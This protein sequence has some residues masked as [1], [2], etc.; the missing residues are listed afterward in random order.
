M[1]GVQTCALPI[2]N[3]RPE[4]AH[5]VSGGAVLTPTFIPGLSLSADWYAI[6]LTGVIT[7]INATTIVNQ[8][9]ATL[10]SV[11]YP[12]QQGNPNDPLCKALIFGGPGGA[13]SG[14]TIQS[15]NLASETVSGLDLAANYNMDFMDGTLAWATTDNY[16]DEN[17]LTSPGIGSNDFIGSATPLQGN[18]VTAGPKW[19]GLVS[20]TYAS[21]P[22]SFTVQSRW[23]GTMVANQTGNTGNQ[24]T[25]ATAYLDLRAN[26]KWNDNIAF[27]GAIDNTLDTPPPLVPNLSANVTVGSQIFQS[28]PLYD[29]LGRTVRIGVRL[30]Y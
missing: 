6:N 30:T 5:T 4:V 22:Y 19:K 14:I 16:T 25:A 26:Y 20:A 17:T 9:N 29:E 23:Y 3:L 24:A 7:A 28:N 12:G 18:Q 13:L 21:G 2:S 11:I 8:C 15:Q 27:Y 10:P 1:T